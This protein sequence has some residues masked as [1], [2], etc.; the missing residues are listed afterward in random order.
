MFHLDG[1]QVPCILVSKDTDDQ[2]WIGSRFHFEN[3]A[4]VVHI[5]LSKE[6]EGGNI[7]RSGSESNL[8]GIFFQRAVQ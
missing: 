1:L 3:V 7:D 6:P 5:D 2:G 4:S 8:Y